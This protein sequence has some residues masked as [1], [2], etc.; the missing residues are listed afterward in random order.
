LGRPPR[1]CRGPSTRQHFGHGQVPFHSCVWGRTW[2][3]ARIYCR[4]HSNRITRNPPRR[5]ADDT[6]RRHILVYPDLFIS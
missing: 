3:P 2:H 5:P 6:I 4:H 1:P